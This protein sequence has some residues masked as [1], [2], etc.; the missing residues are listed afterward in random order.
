MEIQTGLALGDKWGKA[1]YELLPDYF[2]WGR[3][4]PLESQLWIKFYE[5]RKLK[6][7]HS[8]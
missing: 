7:E 3:L 6:N 2:P 5:E 1:L 8:R 4:T